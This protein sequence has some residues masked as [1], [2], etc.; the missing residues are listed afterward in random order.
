M[1]SLT[2]IRVVTKIKISLSLK[3]ILI[4][5]V[6]TL[7][8]VPL[9]LMQTIVNRTVEENILKYTTILTQGILD[10]SQKHFN[11][12]L[13]Q[14]DSNINEITDNKD[15]VELM[16]IEGLSDEVLS[17][18]ETMKRASTV[19]SNLI[20][21]DLDSE[22]NSALFR[23][24]T[25]SFKI[26]ENSE[27]EK[28][29]QSQQAILLKENHSR[30]LWLGT[31]PTGI[32]DAI[33]S[34][35]TYRYFQTG[36]KSFIIA[37]SLDR[38]QLLKFL[39][40]IGSSARSDVLLISSDNTVYPYDDQFFNYSFSAQALNKSSLGRYNIIYDKRETTYGT[41][42]LMIQT[43]TDPQYF[44]NLIIL[45]PQKSLLRGFEAI[46]Q[47][48]SMTLLILA[49]GS[50]SLGLLLVFFLNKRINTFL[51]A[52]HDI[53]KGNYKIALPP[54]RFPIQEDISLSRAIMKMAEEIEKSRN[55]LKYTNEN[56]EKTISERTEELKKSLNDLQMTRQSLLHSEKMAILGRQGAKI[57]HEMNNPLS[58]AITASSHLESTV[59][60]INK[61]FQENKL[62]K[63][64]F[65]SMLSTAAE[66]SNIILRNLRH[67]SKM[68][69][70]FKN[71][72]SDQSR[73]EKKEIRINNYIN[74]IIKNFSYKMKKTTH[75][76]EF[77]CSEDL[78]V[79]TDPSI[80]YQTITNLINNS[81]LH[82]FEEMENGL[83]NINI[84][85]TNNIITIIYRDNGN[86]ISKQNLSQLYKPFFTTKAD[87]GGTGLGLNIIKDLIEHE[88]KGTIECTSELGSGTQFLIKF[89]ISG[90][91][92]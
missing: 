58:V 48:T 5:L 73:E 91:N 89:P 19:I 79:Y 23:I 67:A 56:L 78:E 21:K 90:S 50:I 68:T 17:R 87:Q 35:W 75:K 13:A 10:Q 62:T 63:N 27:K 1:I 33:P 9:I 6:V 32:K 81:L 69:T 2:I 83:I 46:V 74:E 88:L 18:I 82:G 8:S 45:T 3:F 41:E 34:I 28:F 66:V 42:K 65:R 86:G 80:I 25:L 16:K 72:A 26:L 36:T 7:G 92:L 31:S 55:I 43:Y 57:A 12:L 20:L 37:G 40:S 11:L 53:S 22:Q 85:F 59:K 30:E 77:H 47:T 76:I 70:G 39:G 54:G 49:V 84:E 14:L 4:F 24:N 64:D 38:E 29:L 71:F 52:V 60:E 44:Y 51:Y 15:I 61:H